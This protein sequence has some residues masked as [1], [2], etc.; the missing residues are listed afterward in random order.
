MTLVVQ[1]LKEICEHLGLQGTIQSP[2]FL[3]LAKRTDVSELA[4]HLDRTIAQPSEA[5][6]EAGHA[7]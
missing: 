6:K 5:V 1:M 7:E 3:E 4:E 2:K